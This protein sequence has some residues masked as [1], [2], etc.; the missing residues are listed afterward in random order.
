MNEQLLSQPVKQSEDHGSEQ[1]FH[2]QHPFTL[3]SGE[4]L[5]ALSITYHTWGKLNSAGDNVIW[6][7]HALTANADAKDWWPILSGEG[8][9][10]DTEK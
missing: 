7:C 8:L 3:E 4:I 6:V 1:V 5:P 9:A 2:Y 10:F